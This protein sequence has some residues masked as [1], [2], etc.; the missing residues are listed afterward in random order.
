MAQSAKRIAAEI[1]NLK[2][3]ASNS[4][5]QKDFVCIGI[6]NFQIWALFVIWCL[7]S[8]AYYFRYALCSMRYAIFLSTNSVMSIALIGISFLRA[9]VKM[10]RT[11]C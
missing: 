7:E 11:H 10:V 3:Q 5:D 8:G 2:F 1:P 6:L 9:V 4:N